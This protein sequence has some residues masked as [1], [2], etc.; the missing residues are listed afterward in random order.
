M[1]LLSGVFIACAFATAWAFYGLSSI[2]PGWGFLAI[3]PSVAI[4]ALAVA[5]PRSSAD[6]SWTNVR[7]LY[8]TVVALE[9]LALAVAIK[10]LAS[11]GRTSL[12]LPAAGVIVGLHFLP[13]ATVFNSRIYYLTGT[14]IVALGLASPIIGGAT[15]PAV[16]ELGAAIVLWATAL[17][18]GLRREFQSARS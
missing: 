16:L 2:L 7:K 3:V 5:R 11:I 12:I 15:G 10:I 8:F 18:T 14:L 9:V 6:I 13:L 17:I 4:I 1:T